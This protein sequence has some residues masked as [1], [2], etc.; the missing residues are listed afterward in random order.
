MATTVVCPECDQD[1]LELEIDA[2]CQNCEYSEKGPDAARDYVSEVLG[3]STYKRISQGGQLPIHSC[4]S[5]DWNSLVVKE[6]VSLEAAKDG[7]CFHCSHFFTGV[8]Y[9][10]VFGNPLES[11]SESTVCNSCIHS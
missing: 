10:D 5:C 9:C 4:P 3:I 2:E 1:A 6:S 7:V 11:I 8:D